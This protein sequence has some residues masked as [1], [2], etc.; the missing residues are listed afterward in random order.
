MGKGVLALVGVV[1]VLVGV[2][3]RD[4]EGRSREDVVDDFE[5]VGERRGAGGFGESRIVVFDAD[6]RSVGV[7][8]GFTT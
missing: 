2:R 3:L 4:D 1:T 5:G 8:F 7:L 6:V